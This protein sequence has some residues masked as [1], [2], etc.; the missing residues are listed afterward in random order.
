MDELRGRLNDQISKVVIG[1]RTSA[2]VLL[3][4]ILLGGHVLLEGVPGTAK[5]LLARAFARA[6]GLDFSR[7]QFT[8]DMLPADVTGTMT[9]RA[10]ELIFRPGPIFANVVLADEINR[11]PPKTQAALLEAMGE[12]QV[13]V[14]AKSRQLA[15][16]FIVVATQNPIEYEG[17]YPLPE[18]QLD[19]FLMKIEISYPTET[20]EGALLRLDRSGLASATLSDVEAITSADELLALR[21]VVDATVVSDEIVKY[22]VSLI[23]A[24]RTL[25]AV[26][27]GASPR[28]GVHLQ[29]A[30]KF[31]ARANGR[32]FV[33][34][35][36]VS[37]MAPFVLPHRLVMRPEAQIEEYRPADAIAAVL[38]ATPVPR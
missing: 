11:T 24:T 38:A 15:Q 26:E 5:T 17:T 27:V 6:M 30:A 19:R 10:G 21:S 31:T 22:T 23:R 4:A 36:D 34:P 3:A 2:D 13:T 12:A 35:D 20:D 18:A 32:D 7:I 37:A 14:D 33:I 28:A 9:I 8:P 1:H 25:P 29:A 16:P